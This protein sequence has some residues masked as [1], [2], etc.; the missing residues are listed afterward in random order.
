MVC[1]P[2]Q[3]FI[4]LNTILNVFDIAADD[5]SDGEDYDDD[6]RTFSHTNALSSPASTPPQ[7]ELPDSP[8]LAEKINGP[9]ASV[10]TAVEPLRL[11]GSP[12]EP[13]RALSHRTSGSADDVEA[14]LVPVS[15]PSPSNNSSQNTNSSQ[16]D[17]RYLRL[18]SQAAPAQQTRQQFL[19]SNANR[20][21]R[22]MFQINTPAESPLRFGFGL[23]TSQSQSQP[24][25]SQTLRSADSSQVGAHDSQSQ[26]NENG[27]SW[28]NTQAFRPPESQDLYESD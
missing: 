5:Q 2:L 20:F 15:P 9:S 7:Q 11:L 21:R 13:E 1:F 23:N 27:A 3:T 10:V 6:Y 28:L 25:A 8:D 26:T 14:A 17:P 12:R 19:P 18:L 16:D 4:R 22:G 24:V